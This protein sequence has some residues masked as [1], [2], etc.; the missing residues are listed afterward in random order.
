LYTLGRGQAVA[1]RPEEGETQFMNNSDNAIIYRSLEPGEESEVAR[2]VRRVFNRFVAHEYSEEGV[3]EFLNYATA[4]NIAQRRAKHHFVLVAET[5]GKLVGVI[6]IRDY[7][8][9]S[10]LFVDPRFHRRGIARA[11]MGQA[12]THCLEHNPELSQVEVNSSPYAVQ[13]YERLGFRQVNTM[14]ERNGIRY[15]PMILKLSDWDG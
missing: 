2:L 11:L 12:L 5:V 13:V 1:Q 10:L 6:E 9:V 4:T 15:V 3:G 8:H 7:N 14:Q